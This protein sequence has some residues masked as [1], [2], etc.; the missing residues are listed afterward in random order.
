MADVV[1]IDLEELC[2]LRRDRDALEQ[3]LKSSEEDLVRVECERDHI[4]AL[5]LPV[6]E[7][8]TVLDAFPDL[9][10][11]ASDLPVEEMVRR[12]ALRGAVARC[13]GALDAVG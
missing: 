6:R 13:W 8:L 4:Y 12:R 5:C 1:T 7:L 2:G 9:L 11:V 3:D 10:D